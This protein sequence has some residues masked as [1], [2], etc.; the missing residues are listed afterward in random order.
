MKRAVQ[1]VLDQSYSTLECIVVDDGS[2]DQTKE[3]I[4][5]FEDDRIK[6]FRH[7]KNKG[8]SA[9]RNTGIR[10]SKGGLIAF[11]DDDDEWIA[12]K[13]EKQVPLI[14]SLPERF[15]MVYCWMDYFDNGKLVYE[16]HPVLRGDVFGQVIDKQ[17]LGGC[18]TLLIRRSV[19]HEVGSFDELLLRGNDGD[20]IRRVCQKFLVDLVPQVLVKVQIGHSN[21]RISD[22]NSAG[23]RLH[24]HSQYIKLQ[25]FR[26]VLRRYPGPL[27]SI[28]VEIAHS[29]AKLGEWE[30]ALYFLIKAFSTR[31]GTSLRVRDFAHLVKKRLHKSFFRKPRLTL[32]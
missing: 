4:N 2:K 27:S 3:V 14:N 23:L 17:R 16:H 30:K 15:G 22:N 11:L 29:L 5:S 18:P 31:S 1:S 13:L 10:H 28:Y 26:D 12:S 32:G 6:Y 7:E 21:K 20:F 19:M 25:K 8:A 24:I 9:A